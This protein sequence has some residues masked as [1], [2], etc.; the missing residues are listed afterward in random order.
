MSYTPTIWKTGDVVSS[1]NLNK[2]EQGVVDA[3]T[4]D[5]TLTQSGVSA[6]AKA[7]G[8]ELAQ[9]VDAV[10]G[11]GLS[12]NDYTTSDKTKLDGIASGATKVDIDTTLTTSGK[13]ADA[14][15]VGDEFGRINT[16]VG[17]KAD[18]SDTVTL[19]APTTLTL[20][21]N[22][23]YYITG[24]YDIL[25]LTFPSNTHWECWIMLTTVADSSAD[26]TFPS[27]TLFIGEEPDIGGGETWELSIKDGVVVSGQVVSA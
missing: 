5:T 27:G 17:D 10:T 7:V 19:T 6:D 13:A 3:N 16:A 26:I 24:L 4:T 25:T 2:L 22:T 18:K 15:A 1:A 9:K 12:T 14:K 8:D 21:D 20:A 23:E 11:K